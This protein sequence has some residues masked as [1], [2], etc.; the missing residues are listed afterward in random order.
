MYFNLTSWSNNRNYG[1]L[2]ALISAIL[3]GS[4][5]TIAKPLLLTNIT[6]LTL[7]SLTYLI[8]GIF[9]FFIFAIKKENKTT[10]KPSRK[11]YWFLFLI[12]II[13]AAL[14]PFLYFSGLQMTSAS[15]TSIL[16]N[17]EIIFTV[18]IALLF[19]KEKL[20]KIGYFG[21]V[22]SIIGIML[23]S[24]EFKDYFYV[25]FNL[26]DILIVL[27]T[28]LWGLDNNLS[29]VVSK[30]IP[31][32]ITIVMVKSLIG[33]SILLLISTLLNESMKI[34]IMNIPYLLLLGV[35]GFGVSL[36][37]FLKA[38]RILGTL[39]SIMIF[40]SSSIFSLFFS[41]VF[42]KE[43]IGVP[44]VFAM[45]LMIFG[46]YLVTRDEAYNTPV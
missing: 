20:S 4:I 44:D 26:G 28:L 17:G 34:D 18:L 41:F 39:K 7:S 15:N 14:A 31:S 8:A 35:G 22:V 25:N 32:S 23:L 46:I 37:F 36:Y 1:Y 3:F 2:Y 40:S 19:F 27:S 21:I 5:T 10:T 45:L 16:T 42:L 11:D 9:A 12:G 30:R 38:L 13:G 33:G 29:K 24:L 43:V 6:P